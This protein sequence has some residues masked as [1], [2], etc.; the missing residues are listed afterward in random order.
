VVYIL[1]C[2]K[3]ETSEGVLLFTVGADEGPQ[4]INLQVRCFIYLQ[5]LEFEIERRGCIRTQTAGLC[6]SGRHFGKRLD[7]GDAFCALKRRN[8]RDR[9]KTFPLL[10]LKSNSAKK[11]HTNTET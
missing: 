11:F 8:I 10:S 3:C 4:T 7:S 2:N 6:R 5:P 9:N 1:Q